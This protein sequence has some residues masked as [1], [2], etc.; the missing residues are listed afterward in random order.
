MIPSL[1]KVIGDAIQARLAAL[2]VG[3]PAK[4]V[5]YDAAAQRVSVKPLIQDRYVDLATGAE[6]S[7]DLPVIVDVPVLF[8]QGGGYRI[9][10][11]LAVGDVGWLQFADRSLD[12]WLNRGGVVDPGDSRTHDPTPARRSR[13]TDRRSA[14]AGATGSPKRL[15]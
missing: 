1:A 13:S 5:S 8:P 11:P 15:T 12:V 3:L 2:R 9:T 7:E 4:V 10:F 14:W 6:T